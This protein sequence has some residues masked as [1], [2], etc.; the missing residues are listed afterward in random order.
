MFT[1]FWFNKQ[2]EFENINGPPGSGSGS[3]SQRYGS[4]SGS[5]YDQAKIVRKTWIPTALCLFWLLSLKI[6]VNVPS[7]SNKQ[8]HFKPD[9]HQNVMDP[10][11]CLEPNLLPHLN[12]FLSLN[13]IGTKCLFDYGT[14]SDALRRPW[15]APSL[16][17]TCRRRRTDC[18]IRPHIFSAPVERKRL[19]KFKP[20]PVPARPDPDPEVRRTQEVEVRYCGY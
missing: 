19:F 3:I 14:L 12:A 20:D 10:Q 16:T 8:K 18:G 9:S 17:P 2:N 13:G 6:H 1:V 15:D 5:F 11:H 7:K 4:G